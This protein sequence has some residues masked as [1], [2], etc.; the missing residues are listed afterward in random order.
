VSNASVLQ[1]ASAIKLLQML[2]EN[3][4]LFRPRPERPIR[5]VAKGSR[6]FGHAQF[7]KKADG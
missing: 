1:N 3:F 2:L 6:L 7:V 4:K 5:K